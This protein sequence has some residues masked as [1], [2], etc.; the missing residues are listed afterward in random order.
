M[1]WRNYELGNTV[2]KTGDKVRLWHSE[3]GIVEIDKNALALSLV[4]DGK[5]RG[6]VFHGKCKLVLDTIIETDKGAIGR[7]LEKEINAPFLMIGK[8]KELEQKLVQADS[9]VF[10]SKNYRSE[11]D[12]RAKAEELCHRFFG[13]RRIHIRHCLDN[14]CGF[15]FAFQNDEEKLDILV[16]K[17]S[18]I[19]YKAKGTVFVSNEDKVVLKTPF[20]VILANNRKSFIIK[21]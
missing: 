11:D 7:P 2:L 6:Y 12:F 15:V 5:C 9:E 20:E 19:V 14:D 10:A 1:M 3:K 4:L 8:T 18:K 21:R 17:E 13:K 16:A